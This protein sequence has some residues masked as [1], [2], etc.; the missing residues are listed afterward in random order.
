MKSFTATNN[1]DG[2]RLSVNPK[3][4]QESE[5]RVIS[6][7]IAPFFCGVKNDTENSYLFVPSGSGALVDTKTVSD[8]GST[9]S[10]QVYGYDPAIDEVADKCELRG[11]HKY[12]P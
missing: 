7:S 8:Q 11:I 4:I 5:N 9:Y 10:A 12:S 6:I 1:D 3:M 2:V